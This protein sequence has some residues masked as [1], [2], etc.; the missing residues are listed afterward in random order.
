MRTNQTDDWGSKRK[1]FKRARRHWMRQ[2]KLKTSRPSSTVPTP[3][4]SLHKSSSIMQQSARRSLHQ[5]IHPNPFTQPP[6]VTTPHNCQNQQ[7]TEW[8]SVKRFTLLQFINICF[9]TRRQSGFH[10][11]RRRIFGK[12]WVAVCEHK[13]YFLQFPVRSDLWLQH[14]APSIESDTWYPPGAGQHV[15]YKVLAFLRLILCVFFLTH[16]V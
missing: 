2:E 16:K 1:R 6:V 8:K 7:T 11:C 15:H 9:L 4:R 14:L 13:H 5:P 3:W 10:C 12:G